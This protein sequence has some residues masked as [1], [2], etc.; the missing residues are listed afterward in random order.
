MNN[1]LK[2]PVLVTYTFC[3][4][5][6]WLNEKRQ[7]ICRS[8]AEISNAIMIAKEESSNDEVII[9]Q[10]MEGCQDIQLTYFVIDGEP[11]LYCIADK[12]NGTEEEGHQGSVIAGIAPSYNSK[13]I[14]NDAHKKIS[15]MLKNLK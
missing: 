11:Y 7:T 6:V 8:Y 15:N 3:A 2:R 5:C 12:H 14:L 4:D 9:E 13:A 1:E 10:Y